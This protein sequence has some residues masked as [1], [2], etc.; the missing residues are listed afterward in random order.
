[1]S[2]MKAMCMISSIFTRNTA[3]QERIRDLPD[4]LNATIPGSGRKCPPTYLATQ[5]LEAEWMMLHND[6]A[7]VGSALLG[8]LSQD[9]VQ[10]TVE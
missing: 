2:F 4:H 7:K 10:E 9:T 3:V 8:Q 6:W 1:M 5:V